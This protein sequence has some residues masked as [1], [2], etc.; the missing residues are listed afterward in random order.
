MRLVKD[1]K[2]CH[3]WLSMRF[4]AAAVALQTAFMAMP[5]PMRAALPDWAT[6]AAAI[7]LLACAV[8]GRLI[9]QGDNDASADKPTR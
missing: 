4:L 6:R 8:L 1:W 5:D 9:D 2:I 3:R 7:A